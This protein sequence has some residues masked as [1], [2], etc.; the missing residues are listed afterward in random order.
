N[1]QQRGIAGSFSFISTSAIT[2][3]GPHFIPHTYAAGS[4]LLSG[5]FSSSV[6]FGA[7]SSASTNSST[8]GGSTVTFTSDFLDFS[9]TVERDRGL[10]LTSI[11]P[12]LGRHTG[13]NGALNSFRATAGG[14]FSS[15]PAPLINGLAVVPEPGV[16]LLMVAGFGLVGFAARRRTT[17]VA[18]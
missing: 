14:Q 17:V 8:L 10:T 3:T 18:A 16:W 13:L 2:V 7:G 15:D 6:L 9:N 11:V 4:N 1:Y 12:S 5:S